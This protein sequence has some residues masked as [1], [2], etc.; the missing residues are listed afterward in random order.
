MD[1]GW[2]SY[3]RYD[4]Q[5]GRPKV[6]RAVLGRVAGYGRPYL[7]LISLMLLTILISTV[8]SLVP[9]LLFRELIDVA[10]PQRDFGLLNLLALGAIAI[11]VAIGL[12]GVLERHL[13]SRIGEG[14]VFDLRGA[15]YAHM[16][17]M[18]LRFFT[19]VR[20][21]EI[22]ARLNS[23]VIGSQRAI[24]S[25][26]IN[27]ISNAASLIGTLAIMLSLDWRLTLAALVIL[28]LFIAPARRV[29]GLLRQ[30]TRQSFDLNAQMN[31]LMSETL[32]VSGALLVKLF[33]RGRDESERFAERARAVRDIGIR[34]ALIG[35]WFGLGL[36]LVAAVGTAIVF[37]YGG[38]LVLTESLTIGT[39]VAFARYLT[40]LYGPLSSLSNAPVEFATS[41]VSFERVFE[42]LDLPVEI[43]D[44][45]GAIAIQRARGALELEHVSFRYDAPGPNGA[46]AWLNEVKRIR[47]GRSASRS[48]VADPVTAV[49]N[50]SPPAGE[51][52]WALRD[53]SFVIEPGQLVALVGPSGAGKTSLTY[54]LPRLYD[55]TEGHLLLDGHDLRDL[56]LDSLTAQI[57]TVTQE[58]F[59]FHDTVRAN[60][61]YARPRADQAELEAA[62]RQA[63][64]HDFI[65]G[66]P[67]GYDTIV[68]ERG[69]RLSGGEK[70]RVALARVILKDPAILV[71]DEAT[72]HLDSQSE[73][74]IQAALE[75]VMKGRTSLVIAHRLSTIL[76]A[77]QILV[78]DRGR[79]V[80]HGTHVELLARGGVYAGLYETQFRRPSNGRP[81]VKPA[82]G[83]GGDE[84]VVGSEGWA[85]R[86]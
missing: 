27:M 31:G 47:G 41:M 83:D 9:P 80:E 30:V 32:N 2:R 84:A 22:M 61:L 14:V 55:P 1:R 3:I 64:I 35:R 15:L 79:L 38:Y 37:W 68:G 48:D 24:T 26:S 11:P 67:A 46:T 72:A 19:N 12:L 29:G 65:A 60:L 4:E 54:L 78:L 28:P 58:A 70:Q 33:G 82:L 36:S 21:G 59:L 39:V 7:G 8:L 57:G 42:V 62:C 44:R 40:Q 53:V 16:Q 86:W 43:D 73:A 49:A 20:T 71:L 50:G 5:Q 66:L 18:S 69:Y 75:G 34:T 10:L 77:D 6:S 51:L 63:N 81:A 45:P 74:L 76:A 56:T 13:G 23:D 52:R 85:K 25:T 17:R